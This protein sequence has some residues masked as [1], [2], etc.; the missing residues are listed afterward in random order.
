LLLKEFRLLVREIL[1]ESTSRISDI[2]RE[3]IIELL[4][5]ILG[6][7]PLISYTEKLAGQFLEIKIKNGEVLSIFKDAKEKGYEHGYRHDAGGTARCLRGISLPP[8]MEGQTYQFEV[9]K[10]DNRPDYIDYAVGDRTLSIE[11]GGRL[12]PEVAQKLNNAQ[13]WVRFVTRNEITRTPGELS[14]ELRSRIQASLDKIKTNPKMKKAEKEEIE[15]LI[16][17]ALT[18]IWG[19]SILGGTPEGIFASRGQTQFKIP[20]ARYAKIQRLQAPLYAVFSEKSKYDSHELKS[21]FE[22]FAGNPTDR[23]A[24]QIRQYLEEASKGFST[25][26]RS[27]FTP[28]EATELLQRFDALLAGDVSLAQQLYADIKRRVG[29]KTNWVST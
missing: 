3:D 20:D 15:T 4:E 28:Q 2:S 18:E 22:T 24:T 1:L 13:R 26:F 27:F 9:I 21:R 7:T 12:T 14:P 29:N 10:A 23:M 19:E 6:R 11:F 25:G 8:E 16:S 17:S 5:D